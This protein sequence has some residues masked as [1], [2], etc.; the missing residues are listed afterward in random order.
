MRYARKLVIWKSQIGIPKEKNFDM[1]QNLNSF[2]IIIKITARFKKD[3][4]KCTINKVHI[5]MIKII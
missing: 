5:I 1:G 4:R 3:D 2:I